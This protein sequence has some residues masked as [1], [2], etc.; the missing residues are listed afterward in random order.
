M[1]TPRTRR[2]RIDAPADTAVGYLR[3]STDEQVVSGLGLEAQRTAIT[4]RALALGLRIIAWFT[5]EGISG[6]VAPL[7]RPGLRAALEAIRAGQA[8]RLMVAKLDRLGR[9][10]LDV[11]TLDRDAEREGWGITFCDLDIDTATPHGR[12]MLTQF[13][14][15]ARFERD[16]I[17]QRTRDALAV[18]KAQGVR[19]GRPQDLPDDI[20]RRVL[21]ERADGRTLQAIADGLIADGVPTARGGRWQ[22]GTVR[23]VLNSQRAADLA[24][25]GAP[26][27]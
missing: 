1:T 12:L 9:D 22:A 8:G 14:G 6:T 16:L 20:V 5:D 3:V 19:L 27:N 18:K 13:A 26:M 24:A 15:F 2:R 23:H 4:A 7:D 25:E 21:R 10:T 17:A 11:L